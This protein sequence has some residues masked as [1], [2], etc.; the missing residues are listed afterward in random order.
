LRGS[1]KTEQIFEVVVSGWN[2]NRLLFYQAFDRGGFYRDGL[3]S[4]ENL[5][6]TAGKTVRE[7]TVTPLQ[8]VSVF[9]GHDG[10]MLFEP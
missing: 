1:F 6:G 9:P 3:G 8:D 10:I 2:L 5:T 7:A 4:L